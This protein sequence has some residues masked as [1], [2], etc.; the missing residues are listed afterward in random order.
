MDT[1]A[2]TLNGTPVSGRPG[3]TIL[4]LA[5]EVGVKIPTLC[6]DPSLKPAGAC[7]VCLVEEEKSGRLLASCV[8]PIVS[9]MMIHTESTTVI[10]NRKVIVK[11]MMASHPES[12]LLCD[13]GNRCQLRKIAADLGI[14]TVN[15]YPMPHFSG[16]QEVNP[17]I[18]R[19][20]SKCIL[21]GKCIRADQELVVV[22]ALDYMHRGFDARPAT[23]FDGPLE[24]S[25]CT[26][27]G[28][29]VTVCPTGALFER[30]RRHLGTIGVRTPSVC[31]YCGCGCN[32]HVET[33]E[34]RVVS[35]H[36][37][38]VPDLNGRTLCVKGHYGFD[39][40]HHPDR[41]RSPLIRKDGSLKEVEWDE[42]LDYV[43]DGLRRC[44]TAHGPDAVAFLGSSKCTNEENYL[45]Q[46]M[47]RVI[48]GTNNVDNGARIR[49]GP[50]LEVLPLG[51]MTNPLKDLESSDV[52]LVLGSNPSASHPVAGYWI[53]RA[54]RHKGA[55]LIVVD[56]RKTDLA[57]MASVW[58]PVRPGKDGML[59]HAILKT[60]IESGAAERN[61]LHQEIG[62][63]ADL[64]ESLAAMNLGNVEELTGCPSLLLDSIADILLQARLP[65]IVY[66]HGITRQGGAKE[67]I[68]AMLNLALLKGSLGKEGGGIYP[69]DK[70]NNGQGAWDMGTRP[71]GLPGHQPLDDETVLQGFA[72][73]WKSTIPGKVGLTAVEMMQQ[74]E[75]G[76]VKAMYVMGENPIRD[77]P[78]AP[79]I[80]RALSSIEFLVVQDLFLTETAAIAHAV[81][82]ACSFAEKSGSFTNMERRV[83]L[84]HESIE[85]LPQSVP[86]WKILCWLSK[87]LGC[88]MDYGSAEAIMD[89][90]RTVVPQYGGITPEK[91]KKGGVFQPCLEGN[92]KGEARLS[93]SGWGGEKLTFSRA[94]LEETGSDE[95]KGYT[96][97]RGSTLYHFS[98]GTRSTRSSRLNAMK[99]EARLEMNPEDAQELNVAEGDSIRV[100]NARAEVSA[101]IALNGSLP[102]RMLFS[103]LF[104]EKA[105]AL[106]SIIHDRSGMNLCSVQIEREGQHA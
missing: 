48:F 94:R 68:R 101:I 9:G 59:L 23:V 55:R 65:A 28:T 27:C 103:T 56:P 90:I 80:R 92:S 4:E 1:I 63:F 64:K 105:S 30:G 12:C 62:G 22:G 82:P 81:L 7:R 95:G 77:F 37:R 29:C 100:S 50:S 45:F 21:C 54:V 20:L 104:D 49:S 52:I 79:T 40:V 87:R 16:T 58:V 47:A 85:P 67:V 46:K 106:F 17:F 44:H 32:I 69:L 6:H 13:K 19:D 72:A 71:D 14:G 98:G 84:I 41:L 36:P 99:A 88:P 25:E 2:I 97:L 34:N 38:G 76:Q 83:Q 78:D 102:R 89:E 33:F 11:L 93:I 70:E 96:L 31:S 24:T 66:G 10:E 26:F 57:S 86:D 43:V 51:A 53:K 3:M 75:M 73:R 18:Q 91:L 8:T 15:Y 42:A 74:A 5:Q 61:S 35:V 39:Y 60:L